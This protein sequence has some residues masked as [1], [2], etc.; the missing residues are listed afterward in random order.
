[1]TIT[2]NRP[3]SRRRWL[4][5]ARTG[6]VLSG[7]MLAVSV[8]AAMGVGAESL[9]A[10]A[11]GTSGMVASV[12]SGNSATAFSLDLTAP[13]NACPGDSATDG[14]RWNG[15]LVSASVDVA[16]LVFNASG[17][18]APTSVAGAKA[19]P[20]LTSTGGSPLVN[21][22][23]G[24]EPKG[25]IIGTK[26]MSFA[27]FP[28]NTITAGEYKMGYACTKAGVTERYWQSSVTVTADATNGGPAQFTFVLAAPNTT[29]TTTAAGATTT[30][31]G[32]T[33]T[34]AGATTTVAGATTTTVKSATTTTVASTATT[35]TAASATSTSTSTST[36]TT[37]VASAGPTGATA[38]PSGVFSSGSGSSGS[39]SGLPTTGPSHT[40]QI[41]FWAFMLVA[42]G[43][44]AILMAR[45]IRV[46]TP[47]VR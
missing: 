21:Q 9:A 38:T 25:L 26:V 30:V 27:Q 29:T 7:A 37:L 14:Y 17:P 4:H 32:A 47:D 35:T 19:F 41:M 10:G 13:N 12:Q 20:L 3:T 28:A 2:F 34:V 39:G 5:A 36:S 8:A 42:C 43:R 24:T 33:T 44:M 11:A 1:M 22:L 15:Y 18:I 45:P 31:A 23:L 16:T 46:I 6:T 40:V